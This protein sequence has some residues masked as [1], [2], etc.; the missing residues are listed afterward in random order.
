M[1]RILYPVDSLICTP[2]N[3]QS[4][5]IT[6][7]SHYYAWYSLSVFLLAKSLQLIL[8]ISATRTLVSYLLAHNLLICRLRAQCMI[9]NDN[10]NSMHNETMHNETIIRFV[11][12][13]MLNNQGL[14]KCYQPSLGPRLITLNST[15][16]IPHITKTSSNNCL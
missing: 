16:I 4:S 12:C 3:W 6:F 7:K 2:K 9:S 13:G 15:M 1:N 10:I 11:S 8:E 14:G 5:S